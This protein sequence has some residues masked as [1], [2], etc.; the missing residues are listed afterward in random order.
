MNVKLI[1]I[2]PNAEALIAYIARVSNPDNQTNPNYAGLI[3]YLL[4]NSHFSP[5]EHSFATFEIV[6]S[7]AIAAQILR[8]RSFT[9]QEFSQRYSEITEFESIELRKQANKN[10]QS[11]TDIANPLITTGV[12]GQTRADVLVNYSIHI[13]KSTYTQLVNAGIAKEVARLVLPLNTQTT[14]YMTGNIRSWIHYLAL[15][16]D[17]HAQK[18]H[19]LIAVAIESILRVEL[20][21]I[22]EALDSI[23]LEREQHRE[24]IA[25]L[26]ANG[27]KTAEDV[28]R[29]LLA[30][31]TPDGL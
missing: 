26:A 4:R 3:K 22:F 20:P 1:T 2:T 23:K 21:V 11:S 31:P 8:H 16:N 19:R 9:F 14:L 30:Q 10:R 12:E 13:A 27:M 25:I 17:D 24:M 28:L 29:Y 15:R 7:R 18:E 5:F 6:T